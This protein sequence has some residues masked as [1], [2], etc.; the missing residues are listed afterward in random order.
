MRLEF[1]APG[2]ALGYNYAASPLI[3]P[4]GSEA[5]PDEPEIYIQTSRAGHR[6]PHCWLKDGSSTRHLLPTGTS[7]LP[8]FTALLQQMPIHYWYCVAY[9][10]TFPSL[11]VTH[12]VSTV[13][14]TSS[15]MFH[16]VVLIL[17]KVGFHSNKSKS[18]AC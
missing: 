5:P 16:R 17:S 1:Q 8:P 13:S 14:A 6:A 9:D 2:L 12:S 10:Y 7:L 11:H 18:A 15:N 4:G 3:V